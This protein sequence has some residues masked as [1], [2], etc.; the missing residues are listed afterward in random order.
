MGVLKGVFALV[1]GFPMSRTNGEVLIMAETESERAALCSRRRAYDRKGLSTQQVHWP[2]RAAAIL[3]AVCVAGAAFGWG[4]E[5]HRA[6]A[7]G[8]ALI[9]PDEIRPFFV[10]NGDFIAYHSI[11]PDYIPNRT[12]AQKAEHFLDMDALLEALGNP[13]LSAVPRDRAE[14]EKRLGADMLV[15]HGLLPW[16]VQREFDRLVKA[17]RD[18]DWAEARLAAAHLSH[19]IADTTMPLHATKNYDGQLTGNYGIHRRIEVE[20]VHRFHNVSV[21]APDKATPIGDPVE[22]TFQEL[23]RSLSLCPAL[24]KADDD[25][26]AAAPLDSEAYYLKLNN[27]AGSIVEARTRDAANAI[28]GFWLAAWQKAGRPALPP[29]SEVVVLILEPM[30]EPV[31][32]ERFPPYPHWSGYGAAQRDIQRPSV[33]GLDQIARAC[34]P[35]DA[36]AIAHTGTTYAAPPTS[37]HFIS[38]EDCIAA[39]NRDVGSVTLGRTA[40][41]IHTVCR[42]FDQCAGAH[43]VLIFLCFDWQTS[44]KFFPALPAAVAHLKSTGA[45]CC[46][47]AIGK[48]DAI[49]SVKQFAADCGASFRE[50]PESKDAPDLIAKELAPLLAPVDAR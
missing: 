8:A 49:S 27:E 10:V 22:W 7:R 34:A 46:V 2:R 48:F 23:S 24:L 18:R 14:L 9:L 20:L 16:T 15:Q 17:F 29:Q 33:P 43:R 32:P 21:I 35:F 30:P 44:D 42:G 26:Q 41:A 31:P 25:A 38:A 4:D 3:L 11:D 6:A 50:V 45:K 47:I 28:A 5:T 12:Q 40:E 1:R 19:F 13:P 39:S 37:L 36:I